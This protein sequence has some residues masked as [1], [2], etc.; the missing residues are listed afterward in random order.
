V[1]V[2]WGGVWGRLSG[3]FRVGGDFDAVG[4]ALCPLTPDVRAVLVKS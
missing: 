1:G 4:S 3:R 2:F